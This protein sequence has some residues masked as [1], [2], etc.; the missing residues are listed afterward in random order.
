[1]THIDFESKN[2]GAAMLAELITQERQCV[3][4]EDGVSRMLFDACQASQI[5]RR[6]VLGALGV[7]NPYAELHYLTGPDKP[8]LYVAA[9]DGGSERVLAIVETK[10][11]A[12]ANWRGYRSSQPC[13]DCK[14]GTESYDPDQVRWCDSCGR[15]WQIDYYRRQLKSERGRRA[16]FGHPVDADE[17]RMVLLDAQGRNPYD[18]FPLAYGQ[19]DDESDGRWKTCSFDDIADALEKAAAPGY[20]ALFGSIA[21]VLMHRDPRRRA[22]SRRSAAGSLMLLAEHGSK[23]TKKKLISDMQQVLSEHALGTSVGLDGGRP[24]YPLYVSLPSQHGDVWIGSEGGYPAATLSLST[25][26]RVRPELL[27]SGAQLI[28]RG[29]YSYA[30]EGLTYDDVASLRLQLTAQDAS[31]ESLA[32]ALAEAVLPLISAVND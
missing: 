5:V 19:S 12:A 30:W 21:D 14:W 25:D 1:M 31:L 10:V 4:S 20:S 9:S 13:E 3:L 17:V 24:G 16:M 27:P 11:Y 28:D 2:A 29:V 26:F 18:V 32:A 15:M 8:D 6:C 22:Q 7:E 23:R